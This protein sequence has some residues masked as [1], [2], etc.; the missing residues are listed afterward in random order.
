MSY[1]RDAYPRQPSA[2]KRK[3]K[4]LTWEVRLRNASSGQEA[5]GAWRTPRRSRAGL[6][7]PHR[8]PGSSVFSGAHR[9]RENGLAR[10]LADFLSMT[11]THDPNDMRI[12][13]IS[14]TVSRLHRPPP[15]Y[16]GYVKALPHRTC[17]GANRTPS[18]C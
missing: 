4:L 6:Q 17:P 2:R 14:T 5:V 7:D 9:R 11:N 16:V 3:S 1:P 10:A 13:W 18:F 12:H 8:G 15:A